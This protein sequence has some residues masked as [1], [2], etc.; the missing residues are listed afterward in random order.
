[1]LARWTA[2]L[3]LTLGIASPL[4]GAM[5]TGGSKGTETGQTAASP[6]SDKPSQGTTAQ[7]TAR[8]TEAARPTNP[9]QGEQ[10]K[11]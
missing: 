3:I 5:A 8:S 6:K 7:T 1:M 4:G 10:E 9:S 11:Q 2:L